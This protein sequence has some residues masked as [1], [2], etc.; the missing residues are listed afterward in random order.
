MPGGLYHEPL[1]RGG[2]EEHFRRLDA[3]GISRTAPGTSRI[4]P[5]RQAGVGAMRGLVSDRRTV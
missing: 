5:T 2:L 1:R 3:P 4:V